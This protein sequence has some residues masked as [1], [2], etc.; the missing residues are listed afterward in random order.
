LSR[1]SHSEKKL[2]SRKKEKKKE[3]QRN[4]APGP[5]TTDRKMVDVDSMLEKYSS[6]RLEINGTPKISAWI[7]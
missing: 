7:E 5:H 1:W 3:C 4:N 2:R 6:G